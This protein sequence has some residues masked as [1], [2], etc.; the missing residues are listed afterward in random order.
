MEERSLKHLTKRFPAKR[1]FITGAGS[2]LGLEFARAFARG[3]WN[4]GVSDIDEARVGEAASELRQ[5]EAAKI[6]SFSFDVAD[7]SLFETALRKFM[8]DC[9]GG[10][11]IIINNAG[12]GCGGLFDEVGLETFK[13]VI[14]INLM[15][16]VNGC[17]IV[18]PVMKAQ[19]SG[20]IL[21]ISSAAAFVSAPRMSAYNCAKAAVL[22][23]SETL[24]S[25]FREHGIVV[26][27]V[28][29]T[30]IR[31]EI[32]RDCL[33]S[34]EGKSLATHLVDRSQLSSREAVQHILHMMC[35]DALYMIFPAE[36]LFL[37]RLKRWNPGAFW[38]L[39]A[40]EANRRLASFRNSSK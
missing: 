33:G 1:V 30:Y 4:V 13:R 27:A 11:D 9:Q 36:A 3:G 31:T 28:M 5:I 22:S 38:K 18:A 40:D 35:R 17:H 15:G 24:R 2:G 26:S 25:E 29:P 16:V 39:V 37:W 20:Y 12:V 14:D 6:H 34:M 32:G 19:K 8:E 7:R 10:I 21:N 23:L